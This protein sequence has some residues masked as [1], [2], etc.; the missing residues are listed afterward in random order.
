MYSFIREYNC[1]TNELEENK[2]HRTMV[3][4][5]PISQQNDKIISIF[6]SYDMLHLIISKS[7]NPVSLS[8]LMDEL[9]NLPNIKHDFNKVENLDDIIDKRTLDLLSSQH[10][11]MILSLLIENYD[12]MIT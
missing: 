2:N 10:K 8:K 7:K 1:L 4:I 6:V 9:M 3:Y 5:F 11:H 12:K